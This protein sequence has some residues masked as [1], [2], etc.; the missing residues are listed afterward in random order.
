MYVPIQTPKKPTNG[1][2][3]GPGHG[4]PATSGELSEFERMR[5]EKIKENQAMLRKL[6]LP[7]APPPK[8]SKRKLIKMP[9]ASDGDSDEDYIPEDDEGIDKKNFEDDNDSKHDDFYVAPTPVVSRTPAPKKKRK[10]PSR[11]RVSKSTGKRLKSA[12]KRTLKV[13]SL[14]ER[15]EAAA[16]EEQQEEE[17]VDSVLSRKSFRMAFERARPTSNNTLA[18][19][20]MMST[21]DAT[22]LIK[23]LKPK[24]M[25]AKKRLNDAHHKKFRTL[26]LQLQCGFN[27]L[28][29]GVGSKKLL[30][31]RFA[32]RWLTEG[33]VLVVNGYFPALNLSGILDSITKDIMQAYSKTFSSPLEQVDYIKKFLP[34]WA[35]SVYVIVHNIDGEALRE[36]DAQSVLARLASIPQIKLVATIDH[37]LAPTLWSAR[38]SSEFRWLAH[39]VSTFDHYLHELKYTTSTVGGEN[40]D[41]AS[42]IAFVLKSLT[43]NHHEILMVLANEQLES[44]PQGIDFHHFLGLCQDGMLVRTEVDMRNHLNEMKD[45]HLVETKNVD[46]RQLYYI[47]YG[48]DVIKQ[49]ILATSESE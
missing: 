17:P 23:K 35:P 1:P 24:N 27:V 5:L 22:K 48:N 28:L 43:P 14:R 45:H 42:G 41:R 40:E 36:N 32:S 44:Y 7:V 10:T 26:Y 46:G 15:L 16:K 11:R 13:S 3:P 31:Q 18:L 9:D 2:G 39:D 12:E 20:N 8:T 49:K 19:L 38:Q 6:G 33:P 47:P 34:T 4:P 30:V 37:I 29:Y 21:R 25:I